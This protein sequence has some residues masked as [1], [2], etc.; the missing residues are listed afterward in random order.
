MDLIASH[1]PS[2]EPYCYT[3]YYYQN[4]T[5]T[6]PLSGFGCYVEDTTQYIYKQ[7]GANTGISG[8]SSTASSSSHPTAHLTGLPSTQ[9]NST[10]PSSHGNNAW[11]A[12]VVI[13]TVVG[14][15]ILAGVAF[16]IWYLLRRMSQ[17]QPSSAAPKEG[18]PSV[19]QQTIPA[20][21]PMYP[22]VS[23]VQELSTQRD[24]YEL[25]G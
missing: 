2:A 8:V 14:L 9:T 20:S 21:G 10:Q 6:S 5:D 11:I 1:S 7:T 15:A 23:P 22:M 4:P 16:W 3:M 24:P 17:T 19:Q 12:G 18:F 13:G 25:H